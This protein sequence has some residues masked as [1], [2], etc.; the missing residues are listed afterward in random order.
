M[1]YIELQE[2]SDKDKEMI[3]KSTEEI[4][5]SKIKDFFENRKE[6]DELVE[7]KVKNLV[8]PKL[9]QLNKKLDDIE[10]IVERTNGVNNRLEE[11]EKRLKE[12][13]KKGINYLLT[14]YPI[15]SI[16]ISVF[17]SQLATYFISF[18]KM[19][20]SV[21]QLIDEKIAIAI[22]KNDTDNNSSE[23]NDTDDQDNQNV[24]NKNALVEQVAGNYTMY[25]TTKTNI[26]I[27]KDII[28][29]LSFNALS[30]TIENPLW[31][32]EEIVAEDINGNNEYTAK[33]IIG[34]RVLIPYTDDKY[35][36][37]FYGQYNEK[38]HWDGNCVIN[39]Y[40]DGKLYLITNNKY[41]DGELIKYDQIIQDTHENDNTH[42]V[43]KRW[44][45]ANRIKND[46]YNSGISKTYSRIDDYTMEFDF[47]DAN[48]NN[49]LTFKK[50]RKKIEN[51][52]KIYQTGY[53]CGNT[54]NGSYNDDSGDAFL[55]TF[56]ENH[57]IKMVYQGEFVD[58]Y[59]ESNDAWEI[60]RDN[61]GYFYYKGPFEYGKRGDEER[62]KPYL[63]Q[64]E[65]NT[66]VSDI[67]YNF[68][69]A[70]YEFD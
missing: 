14:K 29:L 11:I 37:I 4:I 69:N 70:W 53:Y 40:E 34:K 43:E 57:K 30:A 24:S 35:Q 25:E 9:D 2:R 47:K 66:Y 54:A 67:D 64:K 12:D 42:E 10:K 8:D 55:I 52:D 33:E 22:E 38:Y 39:T 17:A 59:P 56:D 46:D 44:V 58:G 63:S 36:M 21:Q 51:S 31:N 68:K 18:A 16:I 49:V 20:M 3:K 6:P 45:I 26:R 15:W 23:K 65:I 61:I 41:K 62:E 60:V 19:P 13:T 48:V 28:Q 32:N 5:E 7:K 1:E 50:F 27:K